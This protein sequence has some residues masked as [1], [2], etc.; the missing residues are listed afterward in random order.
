[1]RAY[2][3]NTLL[4]DTDT[5]SMCHSLEV[6]VPFLHSPLVEYVLSVPESEKRD[7]SRP[8]A[9]LVAALRDLLPEEIVA[10][11]K[12]TSSRLERFLE[13]PKLAQRPGPA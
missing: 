8:K 2:L 3:V 5:M 9:L 7:V 4:R 10:Q 6:R 12:R 1:M 13:P 11:Q